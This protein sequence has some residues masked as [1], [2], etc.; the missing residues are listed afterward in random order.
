[1]GAEAVV[2]TGDI[3]CV[4]DAMAKG[5]YYVPS[6]IELSQS[7]DPEQ[8][9]ESI[10]RGMTQEKRDSAGQFRTINDLRTLAIHHKEL[11]ETND[12]DQ[13]STVIH[14][15]VPLVSNMRSALAKNA[16]LACAELAFAIGGT[17]CALPT[18]GNIVYA[19]LMRASSDKTFLRSIAMDALKAIFEGHR[20]NLAL[21]ESTLANTRSKNRQLLTQCVNFS[22]ECL[23]NLPDEDYVHMNLDSIAEKLG[24]VFSNKSAEAKYDATKMIWMI[25]T[26]RNWEEWT[27]AIRSVCKP[28]IAAEMLKGTPLESVLECSSEEPNDSL[29]DILESPPKRLR[30]AEMHTPK[31]PDM[32]NAIVKNINV[33]SIT[34]ICPADLIV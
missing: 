10:C 6:R 23:S 22:T 26:K 4:S 11:L 16:I 18:T 25:G 13:L 32:Q 24:N 34:P 28:V 19:L 20:S 30:C 8:L 27:T 5:P 12:R 7:E 2:T 17:I 9:W 31:T 15:L 1:M 21:L 14:S 3:T 29:Q 33:S